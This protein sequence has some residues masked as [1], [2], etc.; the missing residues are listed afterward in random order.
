M[1]SERAA[2]AGSGVSQGTA[3][4]LGDIWL[5]LTSLKKETGVSKGVIV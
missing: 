3:F 5:L 4:I 1:P 2:G